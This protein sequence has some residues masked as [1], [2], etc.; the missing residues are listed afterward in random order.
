MI[1]QGNEFY[2]RLIEHLTTLQQ[3][4]SDFKYGRNMQMT[5]QCKQLGAQ[6]P[7]FDDQGPGGA[8]GPPPG[9]PPMGGAPP[10]GAPPQNYEFEIFDP[11]TLEQK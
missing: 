6:P 7:N 10:G 11:T 9:A 1:H 2:A 8:G 5:D 4:V 3:N